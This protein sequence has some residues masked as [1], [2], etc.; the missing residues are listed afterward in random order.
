MRKLDPNE[1]ERCKIAIAKGV[2]QR[3]LSDRQDWLILG[4]ETGGLSEFK[5]VK[6]HRPSRM[7]WV[8][9]PPTVSLPALHPMYHGQDAEW[10]EGETIRGLQNLSINEDIGCFIFTHEEGQAPNKLKSNV[11]K[12]EHLL[13]WQFT[14]PLVLEWVSSKIS[15]QEKV[16]IYIERVDPL[17][18]GEMPLATI[19]QEFVDGLKSRNSW[20][21]LNFNQHS[22]LAKE[23]LEHPWL[24]YTD[25]LGHIFNEE[26]PE[27]AK[28]TYEILRDKVYS[29]PY[30]QSSLNGPIRTALKDTARPL[31]LLKSLS[32]IS[33]ADI[34]DYIE[35]FFQ[36]AISEALESLTSSEWQ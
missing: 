12:K 18:P 2:Y 5:G 30:R 1:L 27:R 21:N 11:A 8:V 10:F 9:V 32:S 16:S 31:V 28:E 35:P 26:I 25:A 33:P 13:L 3:Q 14:L 19:M 4:D 15:K 7:L 23:P 17:V 29:V 24:G 36:G 34:R 22:I 6:R 20:S